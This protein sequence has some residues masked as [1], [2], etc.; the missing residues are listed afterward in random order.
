[1]QIAE[2]EV[3]PLKQNEIQLKGHS[4]QARIYAEEPYNNFL[5]AAGNLQYLDHPPASDNVRVETGVRQGDEVSIH[6]DPMIAKLVV[7]SETRSE[8]FAKLK[9]NLSAFNVR[10][11]I[12]I[13]YMMILI[14]VM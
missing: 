11:N 8:A 10:R 2:G 9:N 12:F 3:L 1:M 14:S 5:P 13:F 6:Y 4:V 7:W